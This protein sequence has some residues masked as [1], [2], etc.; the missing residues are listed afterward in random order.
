MNR[1]KQ[2]R[3]LRKMTQQEVAEYIGYA[4]TAISMYECGRRGLDENLVYKFCQL[5]GCSADYLLGLSDIVE[6][7]IS[8]ED[9]RLI[10]A[11]RAA[12]EKERKIVDFVL[13]EY[14]MEETESAV[15]TSEAIDEE[16]P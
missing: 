15:D 5:F 14:S 2:L 9:E 12:S 1:V 8:R 13:K 7:V 4:N 16:Q 6:P 10:K 3:K 11:Y